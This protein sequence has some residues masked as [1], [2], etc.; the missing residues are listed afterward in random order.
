VADVERL[1]PRLVEEIESAVRALPKT[2]AAGDVNRARQELKGH[3]GSIRVVAEPTRMRL[4]S[5]R[6]A[7]EAAL[8]R[9][10]G[11]ME[12]IVGS[13]GRIWPALHRQP[14]VLEL[15]LNRRKSGPKRLRLYSLADLRLPDT[16]AS[17]RRDPTVNPTRRTC[18]A[19]VLHSL[20]PH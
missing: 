1:I 19:G 2:L 15:A 4:Y 3:L 20:K 18:R 17:H 11:G 12:S 7:V 10:V 13:G 9:A 6:G 14:A 5:E 8:V 16:R